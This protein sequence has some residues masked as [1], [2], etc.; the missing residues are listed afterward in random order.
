MHLNICL[1]VINEDD[2]SF[3]EFGLKEWENY[4]STKTEVELVDAF[5]VHRVVFIP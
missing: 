2:L 5:P 4:E 1:K 3:L